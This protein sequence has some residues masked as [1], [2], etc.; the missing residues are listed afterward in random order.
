MALRYTNLDAD[1]RRFMR[2]ELDLDT[3]LDK[4]YP[5]PRLNER[6]TEA[7]PSLLGQALDLYEDGWLAEELRRGRL[8]LTHTIRRDGVRTAVP[9]N[10]HTVLAEGEFNRY[11]ARG[12]C[13]RAL[14][15]NRPEVLIYRARYSE[16]PRAESEALIGRRVSAADLLKDLRGSPFET[17]SLGIGYP[18]SGLSVQLL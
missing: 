2:F 1:T 9:V 13:L 12:L 4:R 10:A 15:N 3:R 18:N 8:F 16:N 5:P 7:W 11:Y 14:E 6:G 17:P